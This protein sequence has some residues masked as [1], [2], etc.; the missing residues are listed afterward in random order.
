MASVDL[1]NGTRIAYARRP[2]ERV[3]VRDQRGL[4][5]VR[6][7]QVLIAANDWQDSARFLSSLL[8]LPEPS[9]LG[10]VRLPSTATTSN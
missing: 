1:L 10:A 3:E 8:G 4:M 5:S 9:S 2:A 7:D 6:I